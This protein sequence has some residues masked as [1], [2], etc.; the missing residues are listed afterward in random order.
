MKIYKHKTQRTR[1]AQLTYYSIF[2]IARVTR[3]RK[4]T[5]T[6]IIN[7]TKTEKLT[8]CER[9]CHKSTHTQINTI[10]DLRTDSDICSAVLVPFMVL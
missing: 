4:S 10:G 2:N 8:A 7:S 9:T 6:I 3:T 1:N 5:I